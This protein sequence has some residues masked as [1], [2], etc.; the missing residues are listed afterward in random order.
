MIYSGR[1]KKMSNKNNLDERQEQALLQIEHNACWIAFWG[2][3][4]AMGVELV[5]FDYDMRTMAGEW[6]IFMIMCVYIFA[7][8]MKNGIWDRRL[9]PDA[10]TNALMSVIAAV[11]SGLI[12]GAALYHRYPDFET[13][14]YVAVASA[15]I[16][17]VLCFVCLQ[18]S[19][20]EL[21]KKKEKLEEE[22]EEEL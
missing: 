15:V 11:V 9:K 3:L 20:R 1:K 10:K 17:F 2:L 4:I 14:A 22:P 12:F 19:A 6:I 18:L 21:K 16:V 5:V 13:A 8:C 7:K